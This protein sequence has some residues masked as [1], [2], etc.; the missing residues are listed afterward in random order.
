MDSIGPVLFSTSLN[1][2]IL[3]GQTG[4]ASNYAPGENT[5]ATAMK[6]PLYIQGVNVGNNSGGTAALGWGY[7][8]PSSALQIGNWNGTTFTSVAAAIQAGTTTT[9]G[10]GGA[11]LVSAPERLWS[12]GITIVDKLSATSCAGHVWNGSGFTALTEI[13]V[14]DPAHND[15][16]NNFFLPPE[17]WVKVASGDT[18]AL[19]GLKVGSYVIK[20]VLNSTLTANN[21]SGIRL[22]DYVKTVADGN[23]LSKD[24]IT[25]H[26]VIPPGCPVVPYCSTAAASNFMQIDFRQ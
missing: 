15:F 11:I 17:A 23:S 9:L 24:F 26:R 10:T 21:V 4:L 12:V 22:L 16:R 25:N 18:L 1:S 3:S 6:H 19:A 20:L 13:S 5:V 2:E 14:L 7:R 8:F